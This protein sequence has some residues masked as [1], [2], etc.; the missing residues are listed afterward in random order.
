[1]NGSI[2]FE[3]SFNGEALFLFHEILGS[4]M[5]RLKSGFCLL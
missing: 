1:M 4:F 2:A 5:V 3:A